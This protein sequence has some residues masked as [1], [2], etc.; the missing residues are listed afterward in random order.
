[1]KTEA[2]PFIQALEQATT[3]SYGQLKV[4]EGFLGDKKIIL[5]CSAIGVKKASAAAALLIDRYDPVCLIMSGTA[6]AI[7]SRLEIGDTV[8][9]VETVFHD[10]P[11]DTLTKA[12][13]GLLGRCKDGLEESPPDHNRYFGRVATGKSFVRKGQRASIIERLDPLCVDM[14]SAAVA[15]ACTKQGVPFLAVRS[16][17]DTEANSGLVVFF[18]NAV[19]ASTHSFV[20]VKALL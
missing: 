7:D 18:K 4:Y 20:V 2:K 17:S 16:I 19:L 5:A 11:D 1:M 8:V 15:E 9:A 13:E 6:G 12:D 14:E 3:T 10:R